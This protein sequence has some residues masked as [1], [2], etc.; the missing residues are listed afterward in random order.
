MPK[1]KNK[2]TP[3]SRKIALTLGYFFSILSLAS[4][5]LPWILAP[6]FCNVEFLGGCSTQQSLAPFPYMVWMITVFGVLGI[7]GILCG[8]YKKDSK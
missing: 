3:I 2:K 1:I 6:L 4:L 8:N 7:A 5:A